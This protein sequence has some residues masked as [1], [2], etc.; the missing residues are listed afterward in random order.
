MVL[1]A[2]L[3]NQKYSKIGELYDLKNQFAIIENKCTLYRCKSCPCLMAILYERKMGIIYVAKLQFIL[4]DNLNNA[5]LN[6]F[7]A[8][9]GG[10]VFNAMGIRCFL[11]LM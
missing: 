1:P 7:N 11:Y 4:C 10:D 2:Y 5:R 8:M 3:N 6:V 9:E